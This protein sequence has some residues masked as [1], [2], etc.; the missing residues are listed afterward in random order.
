MCNSDGI[1]VIIEL[2]SILNIFS[3]VNEVLIS[4]NIL[5]LLINISKFNKV[6][7]N[8]LV[9][10]VFEISGVYSRDVTQRPEMSISVCIGR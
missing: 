4:S 2:L 9:I 8:N 5:S 6:R 1:L 7:Y 3:L 10:N